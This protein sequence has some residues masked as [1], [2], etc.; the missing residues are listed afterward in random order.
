MI[1]CQKIYDFVY[2]YTQKSTSCISTIL[3][4]KKAQALQ[5]IQNISYIH[6][7]NKAGFFITKISLKGKNLELKKT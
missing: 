3:I 4:H 2:T 1:F 6:Y 7:S 5:S